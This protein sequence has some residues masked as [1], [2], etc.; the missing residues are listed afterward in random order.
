MVP[1][2]IYIIIIFFFQ[3]TS[4]WSWD[5]TIKH[6]TITK[7]SEKFERTIQ[8]WKN[9]IDLLLLK[10]LE[11]SNWNKMYKL[12]IYKKQYRHF[13]KFSTTLDS[14]LFQRTIC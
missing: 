14:Y 10:A 6:R 12:Y 4:C 8:K 9:Y 7:V 3:W 5:T 1:S 11:N 2:F 13:E